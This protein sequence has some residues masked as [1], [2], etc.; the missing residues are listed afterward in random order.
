MLGDSLAHF[1]RSDALKYH[2]ANTPPIDFT[3]DSGGEN[4]YFYI[5]SDSPTNNILGVTVAVSA[6]VVPEP[7]SSILFLT[8]GVVLV[9][10]KYLK[11]RKA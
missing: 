10:R 5:N 8:G 6:P 1:D 9:G 7:I 11:K 2:L 3:L 4:L